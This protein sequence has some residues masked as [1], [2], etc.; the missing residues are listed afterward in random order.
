MEEEQKKKQKTKKFALV[1]MIALIIIAIASGV[2]FAVVLNNNNM[3]ENNNSTSSITN[4]VTKVAEVKEYK[5]K[6]EYALT[7]NKL[8]KFDLSFLKNEN[9]KSN[10]IYS[11]LSIKYAFKMLEDATT[12]DAKEQISSIINQYNLTQYMNS[13]NLALANAFFI[14]NSFKDS[15][16]EN[17]INGLKDNY[18][19]EVLFDDFASADNI[20]SW[21]K[22][23][24]LELIPNLL[25]DDDVADLKFALVNALGIDMEW[26]D[27]FIHRDENGWFTD[28]EPIEFKHERREVNPYTNEDKW[29][30]KFINVHFYDSTINDNFKDLD[31][32]V[33][34]MRIEATINNYD[35]IK[36]LG[37]SGIRATVANEYVKFAKKEQYDKNHVL[38]DLPLSDDTSQEGIQ[39]TLDEFLPNYVKELD[40]NYHKVGYTTDF[41]FY[42]DADVKVFSKDLKEYNGT[43]LQYI[44]IMPINDSLDTYINKIDQDKINNY[45]KNLRTLEYQSFKE[46]V[47]T[48]IIGFI[49]KFTFDYDLNIMDDLK[50]IGITDVFDQEKANLT[51]LTEEKGVYIDKVAHK[52]NIEFTED[53]IK[54]AAVTMVGGLG[55]GDPFDYFFDVPVEDVDLTFDKPFM[56]LIRDKKTGETWFVGT[57]YEPLLTNEPYEEKVIEQ[58]P[59][60]IYE[61][62]V[63]EYDVV[64]NEE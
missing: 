4:T 28:Y 61:E 19:A 44:G 10:M 25:S 47:V 3:L 9:K 30:R 64:S 52:A 41:E 55:G 56:F 50:K 33:E 13:Q 54:A 58:E 15:V 32:K 43:T 23:N 39:A 21:V 42:T 37:E 45:I 20:N 46:G 24:T 53:G 5:A 18:K 57:V 12:G 26:E 27:K 17:Y 1:F 51:E 6:S 59:V 35:I 49:P 38:G 2:I 14:R 31:F 29:N 11:P 60:V 36:E 22:N 7:D 63:I 16:K 8:S 40:E 62:P 34:G 48:R